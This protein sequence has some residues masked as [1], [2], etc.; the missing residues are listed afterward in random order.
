MKRVITYFIQYPV[1]GD[2]LLVLLLVFGLISLSQLQSSF[3]PEVP[4]RAI[5]IQVVY[6]GAS[7]EEI[8]EGVVL[9]IEDELTGT[10][11]VERVTSVSKENAGTVTVETQQGSDIDVVLQDVKNAVDRISSFPVG[12]EPLTVFKMESE[13]LAFSFALHANTELSALKEGARRVERD[14]LAVDGI[15]RVTLSGFPEEEIAINLREDDLRAYDLSFQQVLN[16]VR[17]ANLE[18]TGGAVKGETEELLIRYDGKGY[19]ADALRNIVV[20]TAADGSLVRLRD[21]ADV[22]DTWA[23]TPA[24]NQYNGEPA[25][26][27]DVYNTNEEDILFITDTVRNYV[28]ALGETNQTIAV[29]VI[30][31]ASKTLQQRIDTLKSNG[32][33]GIALVLVLLALFLNLRLAGWVALSIPVAFAGMFILAGFFGITINVISLFGMIVVIG[34]LVDDGIVISENIY[35]HFE[36][37]KPRLR[38]AIDGT[39]EVLPAVFSAIV[40]TVIAFSAFFFIEGRLGDFFSEMAFIVIATLIFSLVEGALILPAHVA[41]SKALDRDH[42]TNRV[43]DATNRFML[44]QRDKLYAP[45]LKFFLNNRGIGVAIPVALLLVSL[46]A[47]KGGFVKTTFFPFIERTE[48]NVSLT[49]P[50]GTRESVTQEWLDHIE[51]AAWTANEQL[52]RQR[53]DSANVILAVDKRLGTNGSHT[54]SLNILL[55]DME[56]RKPYDQ[57]VLTVT[58]AI[59]D[60]AGTIPAAEQV[61]YGAQSAFGKPVSIG[62]RGN[63]LAELRSATEEL[64]AELSDLAELKDVTDNDQEGQREVR[65]KLKDRAFA[66]GLTPSDIVGQVRSG[67]FGGEVQRL[68]RGLDEVKV[69]VRYAPEG[70]EN[71]NQLAD[72][73]IRT[74]TGASYPLS[75][76]ADFTV[77]RG[78]MAISHTDGQREILVEA[79]V[80]SAKTSV[81]DMI[82]TIGSDILPPIL[83]RHP[84]VRYG[85]EGQ[86][87]E[88]AKSADSGKR[89]VPVILLLMLATIVMTFRSFWQTLAVLLL[90]PFSYIGVTLGHFLHDK[91]IS[92]FSVLGIIALVGILV[93]DSLVF[94]SAFNNNLKQGKSFDDALFDAGVSRFRPII[95][96]SVT[97]IAG[98]APLMLNQS[99][100]AQFLIPMAVSVAY[101]LLISTTTILIL[102]PVLLSLINSLRR[103]WQWYWN[104]KRVSKEAVEPAVIEKKWEP[105]IAEAIPAEGGRGVDAGVVGSIAWWIV[106]GG[107]ALG[108][109]FAGGE[110]KM[111]AQSAPVT[112]ADTLTLDDALAEA[113]ANNLQL[114]QAYINRDRAE[115]TAHPGMAGLLPNVA[116]T[117]SYTYGNNNTSLEFADPSVPPIEANGAATRTANANLGLNYSLQGARPFREYERL[118]ALAVAAGV[119]TETAIDNIAAGVVAAYYNVVRSQQNLDAA[120][121]SMAVSAERLERAEVRREG[122]TVSGLVV[123]NAQVALNGDSIALLQAERTFRDAQTALNLVLNRPLERN[124]LVQRQVVFAEDL[125]YEALRNDLEQSPELRSAE[126]AER[127][128]LLDWQVARAGFWPTLNVEAGYGY[129]R[130]DQDASF[131]LV[132]ENLGFTGTVGLNVPLFTGGTRRVANKTAEM[133]YRASQLARENTRRNLEADLL[134][135]WNAYQNARSILELQGTAVSTA[136]ENLERSQAQFDAGT[137]DGTALREAQLQLL[138]ARNQLA[139]ARFNAKL[140]EVELLRLSGRL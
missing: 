93:N 49:M 15:S 35:R 13:T 90:I 31:D 30:S 41:H 20:K 55:S 112:M 9:K 23:E 5:M 99:F 128:S 33:Q 140:A 39:L 124:V 83:A 3:F 47:I 27:I 69:W 45:V 84:G 48:V 80:A 7:P 125:A 132:N 92:L 134:D 122:S 109:L 102:L 131:I 25:V 43:L 73:R 22:E 38:A 54:G 96:T 65:L 85:F 11:G 107:M 111:M 17:A 57:G 53:D 72:M 114:Q 79:D 101:G 62:L 36:M 138:L 116:A 86:V 50:A 12:M 51:Q 94:V 4:S 24:R 68:Q 37:G 2:V 105:E 133:G 87:R 77:E 64:K 6:P 127:V 139:D 104:D 29:D 71:I 100:Q 52:K 120:R 67:F 121:E 28:A 8:E 136:N 66:L 98:L 123:L 26:T 46:G 82:S 89:V 76:L 95:L 97:T 117:G 118:K 91:P 108:L 60:A 16:R 58:A 59:R 14:L 137:L 113:V 61:T 129:T 88:Q 19:Y 119:Q 21:V 103:F 56:E 1:S 78:V 63:D 18:V 106:G 130:S 10:P 74:A 42:K 75:E 44:M 40:T 135:A 110:N 126:A 115:T 81:T 70:R 32:A 34:I